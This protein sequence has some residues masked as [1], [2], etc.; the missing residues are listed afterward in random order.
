MNK[1]AIIFSIALSIQSMVEAIDLDPSYSWKSAQVHVPGAWLQKTVDNVQ[2]DKPKPVIVYLHGCA[3]IKNQAEQWYLFLKS[4]GFIVVIPDS[5]AL[6]GRPMNCDPSTYSYREKIDAKVLRPL[7]AEYALSQIKKMP[8][9]DK[10]NIFLM[11]HSEGG[12]GASR[13]KADGFKGI[14][15]SGYWCRWGIWSNDD[16][17]ILAIEYE[18]DPWYKNFSWMHCE[19]N[20][21][22]RRKDATQVIL[23]GDGHS[24][25]GN[26]VA[27][28]EVK[29]FLERLVNER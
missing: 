9:A 4:L 29:K 10:N 20:W 8:W 12:V 6:P 26:S 17:P 16:V 24:T 18:T 11:G 22:P 13:V 27:E 1:K 23:S 19:D 28:K 25:D 3:G 7:E 14:I 15:V 2:V 5:Y 21:S